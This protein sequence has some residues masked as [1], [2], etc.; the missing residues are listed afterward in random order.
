MIRAR[1]YLAFGIY[2]LGL[3]IELVGTALEVL[4]A[5]VEPEES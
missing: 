2:M 1:R 3:V 5:W 4:A